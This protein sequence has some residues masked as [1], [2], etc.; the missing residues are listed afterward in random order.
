M[1]LETKTLPSK[2]DEEKSE[3]MKEEAI[4]HQI[5]NVEKIGEAG[6]QKAA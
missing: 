6:E 3:H 1:D 4:K 5:E 2:P